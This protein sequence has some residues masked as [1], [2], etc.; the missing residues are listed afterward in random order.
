MNKIEIKQLKFDTITGL[1]PA[2]AQDYKTKKVLMLAYMNEESLIK[3]IETGYAHYWSRSR[4]K[5][6]M[7]GETSGNTQRVIEI[8]IDCDNDAILLL[9]DQK[10]P[11]CHTGNETCFHKGLN[12]NN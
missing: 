5:L 11:A 8:L 9:V 3:T 6:W 4:N 7:K 10:G 2:I 1:I 12:K